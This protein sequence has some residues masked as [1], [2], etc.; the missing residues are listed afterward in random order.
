MALENYHLKVAKLLIEKGA[1]PNFKNE[2]GLTP[3]MIVALKNKPEEVVFLLEHGADP[4]AENKEGKTVLDLIKNGHY[5]K[6]KL[7]GLLLTPVNLLHFEEI[8]KKEYKHKQMIGLL[9]K[10]G[11]KESL[12]SNPT[13]KW[14]S[15][16]KIACKKAF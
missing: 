8:S 2:N 7:N 4:N 15:I 1:D 6:P 3:L 11:A 16:K 14:A 5:E 13:S 12:K 9:T 10:H